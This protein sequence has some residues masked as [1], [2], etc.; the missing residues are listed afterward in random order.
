MELG[1]LGISFD[2]GLVIASTGC[3]TVPEITAWCGAGVAVPP[4]RGD[5][6]TGGGEVDVV[7]G[8]GEVVLSG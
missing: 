8:G 7:G 4:E 1:L 2:N 6:D 5:T 3:A